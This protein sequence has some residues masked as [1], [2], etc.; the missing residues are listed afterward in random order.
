ML[1]AQRLLEQL[2]LGRLQRARL[3]QER[4]LLLLRLLLQRLDLVLQPELR[5]VQTTH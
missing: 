4:H 3:Q 1:S 5:L 2:R